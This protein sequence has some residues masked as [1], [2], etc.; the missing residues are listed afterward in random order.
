MSDEQILILHH[1]HTLSSINS[2]TKFKVYNKKKEEEEEMG[3]T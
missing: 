2:H 1:P 3:K